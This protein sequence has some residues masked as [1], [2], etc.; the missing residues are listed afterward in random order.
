MPA[1]SF[2]SKTGEDT[3]DSTSFA[4]V[5]WQE[6]YITTYLRMN[7]TPAA[8]E[9]SGASETASISTALAIIAHRHF[10]MMEPR[11]RQYTA[12]S[13]GAQ[14]KLQEFV[15]V[16]SSQQSG[17][18]KV[19]VYFRMLQLLMTAALEKLAD[20]ADPDE[21]QLE[22]NGQ[23]EAH[24]FRVEAAIQILH[25]ARYVVNDDLKTDIRSVPIAGRSAYMSCAAAQIKA[26]NEMR[27]WVCERAL[28]VV[29]H[30][31]LPKLRKRLFRIRSVRSGLLSSM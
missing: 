2:G 22:W 4:L 8:L 14:L 15:G 27:P 26:Y 30:R 18:Q 5:A 25:G 11:I 16:L 9:D 23:L 19:H 29:E 24:F 17:G 13:D 10:T 28:E 1:R 7:N 12:H 3:V 31:L 20:A 6:R 21:L